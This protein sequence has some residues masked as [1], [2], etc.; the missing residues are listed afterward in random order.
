MERRDFLKLCSLAGL[1]VVGSTLPAGEPTA[2]AAGGTFW[3]LVHAV[4][5]WDTTLLFDPKGNGVNSEGFAVNDGFGAGEILTAG[6]IAYAPIGNNKAFFDR[7]YQQLLVVRG[8]DCETNGHDSG[9]RN[10]WSGR[11]NDG[12][13]AFGALLAAVAAAGKPMSFITN[14][15][16]DYTGG[17]VA[18]T[19][20]GNNIDSLQ[21]LMYP[22]RINP[23]QQ[24]GPTYHTEATYARIAE[25]RRARIERQQAAQHL[26]RI[27]EAMSLLYTSRL[28]MA[29]L[30][31]L[32]EYLP[33][34]LGN[35][36]RRQ[37]AIAVAAYKSGLSQ[38]ANLS[39][40]GFDSHGNN[41]AQQ[42]QQLTQLLQGV[43][44]L[45]DI[46]ETLGVAD[47]LV[48]VMGS[49]FG[50]TPKYNEGNG[51]DHWSVGGMMLMGKGIQGNR[52]IGETTDGVRHKKID[53]KTLAPSEGGIALKNGHVHRWLRK[54]SAIE[55]SDVVKEYPLSAPEELAL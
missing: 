6:N 48:V 29:D 43:M 17:V 16:Y 25:A 23:Q 36:M 41:D 5:G 8:I 2:L 9:Q 39:L 18:P 14:G 4:G 50:R 55:S 12:T 19:R 45:Y 47:E 22:N 10:T 28:G 46:A 30:K 38:V 32:G 24:D 52:V 21:A 42:E 31:K 53:P 27:D 11:L 37:A 7:F 51:K 44:D 15:G 49:D 20:L 13:P 3:V 34:D 26:P 1:G 40:G 33:D 54:I 35:G